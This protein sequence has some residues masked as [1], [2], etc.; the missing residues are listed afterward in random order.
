MTVDVT[1]RRGFT[2]SFYEGVLTKLC[3]YI[4]LQCVFV[5]DSIIQV[6]FKISF[7][8]NNTI[9]LISIVLLGAPKPVIGLEPIITLHPSYPTTFPT[10]PSWLCRRHWKRFCRKISSIQL[11]NLRSCTRFEFHFDS[12]LIKLQIVSKVVINWNKA[13]RFTHLFNTKA[14][15]VEVRVEAVLSAVFV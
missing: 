14:V 12:A 3:L 11:S 15:E 9:A 7:N 4:Y 8:C 6:K 13:S 1:K 2:W 5:I 10:N